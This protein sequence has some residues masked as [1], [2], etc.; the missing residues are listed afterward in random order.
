MLEFLLANALVRGTFDSGC[1][2][3]CSIFVTS[4]SKSRKAATTSLWFLARYLSAPARTVSYMSASSNKGSMSFWLSIFGGLFSSGL[5]NNPPSSSSSSSMTSDFVVNNASTASASTSSTTTATDLGMR[6]A[7]S[8]DAE[9]DAEAAARSKKLAEV[10]RIK[11]E[12]AKLLQKR[13]KAKV[14]DNASAGSTKQKDT[15]E[16]QAKPG[17]GMDLTSGIA[18]MDVGALRAKNAA[19]ETND[20]ATPAEKKKAQRI[21]MA[22]EKAFAEA[23]E[24]ERTLAGLDAEEVFA[25]ETTETFVEATQVTEQAPAVVVAVVDAGVPSK[26]KGPAGE[27]GK[28]FA[29]PGGFGFGA[30]SKAPV[31]AGAFAGAGAGAASSASDDDDAANPVASLFKKLT[32][33]RFTRNVNLRF[34]RDPHSVKGTNSFPCEMSYTGFYE[35]CEVGRVTRVEYMPNMNSVKFFLHDTTEVFFANLPYDPTL[36][37]MMLQRGV[38][39][40]SRQYGALELFVRSTFNV[41]TP[42]ILVWFCWSVWQELANDTTE[43][44]TLAN[45][46]TSKTYSSQP[47]TGLTMKD[48]AGIDVVREEMEELISYLREYERYR[49]AGAVIPAGVLLCGPPGTGKTL[50]ARCLAG[51]AQVPFFSCAGTEF[52]EMF[53][54]VGAAR[55]RNLFKQARAVKP[56]IVFIDE[57]DSVAVRRKDPSS[58]DVS[59]ND[60]QVA[61]I[62][63]LL[64]EMDGFGGNSG[65][66]VFAA[67][68]RP[69]VIDPAL[70][71]PGRFDRVVEMPL[72]NRKA[73]MDIIDLHCSYGQFDGLIDPDLQVEFVARQAAGFTGADLENLVRTAALRNASQKNGVPAGDETFLA[74]IDEIRRSNV[75]KATGS[76]TV[77][78]TNDVTENALIQQMNPYVRDTVCTYYAAQTLVGMMAPNYDDIAKVRVFANGEE[79]GQIVYVPDEVGADGAASVK[80]RTW[81]ESKMTV[82]VAGQMAE[83]YLYGPDKV[84]QYGIL[85]MKEATAMA[86]EMVMMHGW[87]DLGPIAVL[88]DLSAEEKY[89]KAGKQ[90]GQNTIDAGRARGKLWGAP[91]GGGADLQGAR[92]KAAQNDDAQMLLLGISDEL[93]LLI[94][95]EVRKIFVQA[96]QRAVMIMHD[97]KG[98]EMLFTLREA[99]ATAKEI[100]GLNLHLVFDKFGLTKHRDFNLVDLDWGKEYELYWDEFVNHIWADDA[101]N[102]GFWKLVQ[103]QWRHTVVEPT[104]YQRDLQSAKRGGAEG[105]SGGDDATPPKEVKPDLPEWAR[106]YVRALPLGAREEMLMYAP[107]EVQERIRDGNPAVYDGPGFG[108]RDIRTE[109]DF[110]SP[111]RDEQ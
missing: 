25:S 59:G 18:G 90:K 71:R 11:A 1:L 50:L 46:G 39:I 62:N 34:L 53:V 83:R 107:K 60:E 52:M 6:L 20:T 84:S 88:Q 58:Q 80:R 8:A 12:R 110:E 70:I 47:R 2:T 44:A 5:G 95:N 81:F 109:R 111:K 99:L 41:L 4:K 66:M 101:N 54:G 55:I 82:L 17:G 69:H 93:D 97:P 37:P 92:S 68:N 49:K 28:K 106:E 19:A 61:T 86:C 79:T 108:T 38:D 27:S 32:G 104:M 67:T 45:T 21:A 75:F 16:T 9:T 74:V 30:S 48:I 103:E 23:L 7:D 29:M 10:R 22:K 91:D 14:E 85:D 56:C 72:P 24:R 31:G 94:A 40:I 89:L 36:Y 35:L 43:G 105:N 102:T 26:K 13:K 64:T 33:P 57:F 42:A 87:S 73:R 98:T 63:Q 3:S 78:E 100:N 77:G 96:C 76:G 15:E 65:V 51:E